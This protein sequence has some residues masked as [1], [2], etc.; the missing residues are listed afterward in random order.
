MLALVGLRF[1]LL[2]KGSVLLTPADLK[3]I[4]RA[5]S[6]Q[7]L[8]AAAPFEAPPQ[9]PVVAPAGAEGAQSSPSELGPPVPAG[10]V[11]VEV[12]PKEPGA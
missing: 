2:R 1:A 6:G 3:A 9:G 4:K 12:P 8:P 5:G 10:P 11:I 7:E